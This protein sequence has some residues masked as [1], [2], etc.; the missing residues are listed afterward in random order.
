MSELVNF[1]VVSLRHART[2]FPKVSRRTSFN[3]LENL[4]YSPSS[5]SSNQFCHLIHASQSLESQEFACGRRGG[6]RK[7]S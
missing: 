1:F 4:S 6:D 5:R 3:G 2:T 7:G